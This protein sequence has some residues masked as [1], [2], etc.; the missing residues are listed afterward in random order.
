MH[1]RKRKKSQEVLNEAQN[2]YDREE[3]N[4]KEEEKE[5]PFIREKRKRTRKREN[6]I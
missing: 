6:T 4:I 2:G 5:G 3:D 1:R